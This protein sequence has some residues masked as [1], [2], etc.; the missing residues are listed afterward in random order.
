MPTLLDQHNY[1]RPMPPIPCDVSL[2]GSRVG[3]MLLAGLMLLVLAGCGT[4]GTPETAP[5]SAS[6]PTGE[7]TEGEIR[8][9]LRPMPPPVRP[10]PIGRITALIEG[11]SSQYAEVHLVL[12]PFERSGQNGFVLQ[13]EGVEDPAGPEELKLGNIE[14]WVNEFGYYDGKTPMAA[15]ETRLEL[16]GSHDGE[17]LRVQEMAPAFA[18]A[19]P[20]GAWRENA[21]LVAEGG[22]EDLKTFFDVV[23]GTTDLTTRAK[24]LDNL[25]VRFRNSPAAISCK[26]TASGGLRVDGC[27]FRVR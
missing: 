14:G 8:S 12:R 25:A 13:C 26:V 11:P 18:C 27:G 23:V 21:V 5:E 22:E 4:E 2:P 19:S 16:S 9:S 24:T 10:K 1:S 20:L 15:F 6:G 17:P 7:P 3:R